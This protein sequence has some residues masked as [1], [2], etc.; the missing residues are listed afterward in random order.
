M[1]MTQVTLRL[2]ENKGGSVVQKTLKSLTKT[3]FR[4][5]FRVNDIALCTLKHI[6]LLLRHI[7]DQLAEKPRKIKHNS[8]KKGL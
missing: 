6:K 8:F 4:L 5:G 2:H 3:A 7:P 1:E